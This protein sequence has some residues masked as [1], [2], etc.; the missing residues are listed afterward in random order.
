LIESFFLFR[1]KGIKTLIVFA[2]LLAVRMYE[3]ETEG[4]S[5]FSPLWTWPVSWNRFL[6]FFFFFSGQ[7][8]RHHS[9]TAWK[10]QRTV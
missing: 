9:Q 5:V 4:F 3:L 10:S 2:G 6:F 1:C 7:Q 8:A